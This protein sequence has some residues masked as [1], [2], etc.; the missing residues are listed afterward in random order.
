MATKKI[1][2]ANQIIEINSGRC[3]RMMQVFNDTP[4]HRL[5]QGYLKRI[6]DIYNAAAN[7]IAAAECYLNA[8]CHYDSE[9]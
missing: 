7:R 5:T 2:R 4:S 6:V 9:Q 1:D 8:V 3:D